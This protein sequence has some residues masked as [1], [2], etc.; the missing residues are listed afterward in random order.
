MKKKLLIG[1]SVVAASAALLGGTYAYLTDVE[2][3]ANVFTIG[4]VDI[5]FERLDE[6]IRENFSSWRTS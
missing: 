2:K 6:I 3:D 1:L 4:N 5:D